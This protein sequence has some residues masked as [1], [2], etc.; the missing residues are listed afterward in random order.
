MGVSNLQLVKEELPVAAKYQ[1]RSVAEQNS[2]DL[3]WRLLMGD[4]YQNLRNVIYQT[5]D[6]FT[7]FRSLVVNSVLGKWLFTSLSW[8]TSFSTSSI[9]G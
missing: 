8:T 1:G 5:K 7:R 2:V 9:C 6:E 3:S 4:E